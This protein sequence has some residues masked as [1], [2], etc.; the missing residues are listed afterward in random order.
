MHKIVPLSSC[1]PH[2]V[3]N[4]LD[5]AFGADRKGRTAYA[6]RTGIMPID[7][8]SFG[9]CDDN[10]LIASIQCWPI[11]LTESNFKTMPMV[12]VG[13]VAVAPPHQRQG[14]GQI[15]MDAAIKA[16]VRIGNP[17]LLMIGDPEYYGRFGFTSSETGAMKLPGP[18]EARRLLMRNTGGH[19]LPLAGTIGP[20]NRD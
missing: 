1:A 16:S 5:A 14:L 19:I 12:L 11:I 4:L 3:D 2:I 13:P 9:V 20:D 18:W 6:L 10:D 15:L 8:L 17:P 7:N